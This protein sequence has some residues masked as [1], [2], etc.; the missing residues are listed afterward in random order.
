MNTVVV[1]K[2]SPEYVDRI[3]N[4]LR[5]NGIDPV[6][7]DRPSAISLWVSKGTYRI[8]IAVPENQKIAALKIIAKEDAISNDRVKQLTRTVN[9]DLIK[10]LSVFSLCPPSFFYF[11]DGLYIMVLA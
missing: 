7:L 1:Y 4:L 6:I 5:K 10:V 3:V 2:S 8:R 9:R 11:Y